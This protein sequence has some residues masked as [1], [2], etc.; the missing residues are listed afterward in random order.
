MN[1]GLNL[2]SIIASLFWA[3]LIVTSLNAH[4][5]PQKPFRE[6]ANSAT[7]RLSDFNRLLIEGNGDIQIRQG[8]ENEL[9][10]EADRD[11]RERVQVNLADNRLS[12]KQ[13]GGW[14][15]WGNSNDIRFRLVV[16]N[17]EDIH[18]SGAG[19]LTGK[20]R[21]KFN[22]L[23]LRLAGAGDVDFDDLLIDD[24]RVSLAG[25]GDVRLAG[26]AKTVK[27]S[28]AGAGDVAAEKMKA[29]IVSVSIA[30]AGDARI[31]ATEELSVSIA[32]AG[33]VSHW[34]K[35]R[36]TRQSIAGVGSISAKGDK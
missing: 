5:N 28:V 27:L 32:G 31:W 12:L 11:M 9:V 33:S 1:Y 24:L 15:F 20:G 34:G 30:G 22:N 3:S 8:T 16:K 2:R 29:K 23:G 35:A 26:E 10:I 7:Y 14:R 36:I 18:M 21:I 4:A 13:A 19:S 6:D 17:L 25:A